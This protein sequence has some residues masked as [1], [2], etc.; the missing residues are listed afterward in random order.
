MEVVIDELG[1]NVKRRASTIVLLVVATLMTLT[2]PV[3]AAEVDGA[4]GDEAKPCVEVW[5]EEV[6]ATVEDLVPH[7]VK[8]L[9]YDYSG[10]ASNLNLGDLPSPKLTSAATSVATANALLTGTREVPASDCRVYVDDPYVRW[11]KR[12]GSWYQSERV[13]GYLRVENCSYVVRQDFHVAVAHY[14]RGSARPTTIGPTDTAYGSTSETYSDA[15]QEVAGY[16]PYGDCTNGTDVQYY[17]DVALRLENYSTGNRE[18]FR[19]CAV[20]NYNVGD[21][22]IQW[23]GW[24]G[25]A[26]PV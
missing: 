18:T 17:M 13:N 12:R 21:N 8:M 4:T 20:W 9:W 14:C 22:Y 11:Y 16:E 2:Y 6:C 1:I 23:V 7:P 15:A 19:D 10:S 26:C 24:A 5:Y 3:A 25:D